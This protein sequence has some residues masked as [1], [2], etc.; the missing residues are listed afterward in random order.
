MTQDIL[1]KDMMF[2]LDDNVGDGL[3]LFYSVWSFLGDLVKQETSSTPDDWAPFIG[4]NNS[5]TFHESEAACT[6]SKADF[7]VLFNYFEFN[8]D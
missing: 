2:K 7:D 1:F 6:L 8:D 4:Q 3:C 5:T